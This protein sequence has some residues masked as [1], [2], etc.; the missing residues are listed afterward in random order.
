M[1][2]PDVRSVGKPVHSRT[3]RAHTPPHPARPHTAL[4]CNPKS[5]PKSREGQGTQRGQRGDVRA[6]WRRLCWSK[7]AVSPQPNAWQAAWL[8]VVAAW[9][10]V[11]P[12]LAPAV[13]HEDMERHERVIVKDLKQE[14]K[15][16]KEKL[17]QGHR[18]RRKLDQIQESARKLVRLPLLRK[19]QGVVLQLV[20]EGL[21][22]A[23]PWQPHGGLLVGLLPQERSR[24][25]RAP[26][27]HS[28]L[29]NRR[30]RST[31]TKTRL[32]R[33]K[34]RRWVVRTRCSASSMTASRRSGS[35]T[36]SSPT[37]TSQRCGR[38]LTRWKY[39]PC[40]EYIALEPS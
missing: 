37:T 25:F 35:T 3:P 38:R 32:V 24:R 34:L 19:L 26:G 4:P 40:L 21:G 1:R 36:A 23:T 33:R 28:I 13:L 8:A 31:R 16:H 39:R 17:F 15:S 29:L 7:R 2:G 6:P 14:A 30:L 11:R 12:S 5:C 9:R 10:G 18:V 22:V 20:T 27:K